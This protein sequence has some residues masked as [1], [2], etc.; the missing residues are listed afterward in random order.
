VYTTATDRC[1][2]PTFVL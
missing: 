2:E 1:L